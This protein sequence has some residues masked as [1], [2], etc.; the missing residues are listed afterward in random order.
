MNSDHFFTIG[1]PHLTQG[2]PCEDF[3]L[4]GEM[5]PGL[6]FG[7]VCDGCSGAKASTDVGARA[8]AYAFRDALSKRADL[9]NGWFTESFLAQLQEAFI[10]NQYTGRSE[11]FLTTLVG[12]AATP[13][14]AGVFVFGDGAVALRYADGRRLLIECSWWDNMPFYLQYRAEPEKYL[15]AFAKQYQDDML[16]PFSIKRTLFQEGAEGLQLLTESTERLSFDA[17]FDGYRLHLNPQE[18]GVEAM[19]VLTDGYDRIGK[20]PATSVV[21]AFLA[22][23]NHEGCFVKRRLI[24]ALESFAKVGDHPLDDVGIACIWFGQEES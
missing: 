13:T 18:E 15:E 3:A 10:A 23:K 24:R 22:F 21:Q 17:A 19:A 16:E 12:M 9:S 5:R 4:S 1:K 8:L 20:Q 14:E 2:T 11:D 7:V 6:A